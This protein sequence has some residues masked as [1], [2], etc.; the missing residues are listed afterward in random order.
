MARR[1][2][3]ASAP[4]GA[5]WRWRPPFLHGRFSEALA[6]ST[7]A[8]ALDPLAPRAAYAHAHVL[9][10]ARRFDEWMAAATKALDLDRGYFPAYHTLGQC[11]EGRREKCSPSCFAGTAVRARG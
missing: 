6:Q 9:H 3:P 7:R 5:H 10:Y 1:A 11:H 8:L 2:W 4:R